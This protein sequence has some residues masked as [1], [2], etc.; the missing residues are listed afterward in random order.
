MKTQLADLLASGSV[1]PSRSPYAAPVL[2]V[3]KKKTTTLRMCC[4]FRLLKSQTIKCAYPLPTPMSL[5]DQLSG[6]QVYS[7]LDLH[8]GYY[9]ICVAAKDV[10]KTALII[11]TGLY[12]W[13]VMP[14]GLYV[15]CNLH[16]P[17]SKA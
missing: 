7:K 9:Q 10:A 13:K 4:G 14:F 12:E 1:Q 16:L 11:N 3:E 17:R 15:Q 8:S 2:F 5:I 6:A